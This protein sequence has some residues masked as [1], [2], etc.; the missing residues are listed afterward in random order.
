MTIIRL[1]S[2]VILL[3]ETKQNTGN[4]LQIYTIKRPDTMKFLPG[5]TVFPG[6]AMEEEDLSEN[7]RPFI[8]PDI[9]KYPLLL[10]NSASPNP[11]DLP[12]R[13]MAHVVAAIREVFEE[14]GALI[15][16]TGPK[17]LSPQDLSPYR[18]ALEK[19]ETT[20]FEV[21]QT[22]EIKLDTGRLLHIGSRLTPPNRPARFNTHFYITKVPEDILMIPSISEV[23]SDAWID[24]T[25]AEEMWKREEILC[26]NPTK[27]CF[28]SLAQLSIQKHLLRTLS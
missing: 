27:D 23:A 17:Y 3:R 15:C 22:L 24:P 28:R 19:K 7:W 2:T 16:Q 1:A 5:F 20:F 12:N 18:G 14:T 4:H 6:G 10:E 21:I 11:I 13:E 26:A 8:R 25:Q 9:G